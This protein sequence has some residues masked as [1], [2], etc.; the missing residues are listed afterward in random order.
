[1]NIAILA[2]KAVI[3]LRRSHQHFPSSAFVN[4]SAP[5]FRTDADQK[6]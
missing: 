2:V 3:T 5:F 6:C 4:P 1:M